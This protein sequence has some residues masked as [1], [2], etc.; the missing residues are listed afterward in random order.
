VADKALLKAMQEV[1]RKR[2]F[3]VTVDLGL[4]EGEDTIYTCDFSYDYVKIN[5]EYTT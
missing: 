5:A 1:M 4:G 3:E 2:A